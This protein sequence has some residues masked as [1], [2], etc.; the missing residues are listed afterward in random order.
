MK[1]YKLTE[2]DLN[3]YKTEDEVGRQWTKVFDELSKI[4][5]TDILNDADWK[6][7]NRNEYSFIFQTFGM[8]R[9]RFIW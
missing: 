4:Y 3:L 6:K 5:G 9:E 8:T 1:K 2:N 7:N